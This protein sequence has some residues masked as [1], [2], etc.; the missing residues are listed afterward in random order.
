MCPCFQL[1]GEKMAAAH[2]LPTGPPKAYNTGE[3][4]EGEIF[5]CLVTTGKLNYRRTAWT[6]EKAKSIPFLSL[7][8]FKWK[9]SNFSK[10][11]SVMFNV[12]PQSPQDWNTTLSSNLSVKVFRFILHGAHSCPLR[13]PFTP[14]PA[15]RQN[16]PS[17]QQKGKTRADWT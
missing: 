4:L 1:W 12:F 11:F 7:F 10:Y 3:S 17:K 5:S 6:R 9:M 2:I 15:G 13:K 16:A 8:F 14:R